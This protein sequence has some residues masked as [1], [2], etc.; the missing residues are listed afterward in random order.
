LYYFGFDAAPGDTNG[1]AVGDVWWMLDE[2]GDA[3]GL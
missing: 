2:A 1:L 3:V